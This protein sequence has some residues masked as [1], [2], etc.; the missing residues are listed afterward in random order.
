MEGLLAFGEVAVDLQVVAHHV[1]GAPSL[2]LAVQADLLA[3]QVGD[4]APAELRGVDDPV[5]AGLEHPVLQRA[6]LGAGDHDHVRVQ[7]A[8]GEGDEDVVRVVG[9]GRHHGLR[10]VYARAQQG[11]VGGRVAGHDGQARGARLRQALLVLLDDA[12]GGAHLGQL[13]ADRRADASVTA[14]DHVFL[15]SGERAFHAPFP[16]VFDEIALDEQAGKLGREGRRGPQTEQ[17][18]HEGEGPAGRREFV[19]LAEADGRQGDDRHV[20]GV[21]QR[22][23]LDPHITGRTARDD[24]GRD[25]Q[26]MS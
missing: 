10:T 18:E 13:R 4:A 6:V 22:P 15:E 11:D 7:V 3:D 12:D 26:D 21:E 25:D 17:H 14:D 23:V 8:R 20:E 9:Q 1:Q 2:G 16:P 19:H 5:H 24:G